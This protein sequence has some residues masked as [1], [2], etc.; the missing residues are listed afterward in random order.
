MN[1][2]DKSAAISAAVCVGMDGS[3]L[4]RQLFSFERE[5]PSGKHFHFQENL[6]KI[7]HK[8]MF[9]RL[10]LLKSGTSKKFNFYVG[11]GIKRSK[12]SSDLVD[13]NFSCAVVEEVEEGNCKDFEE[14]E[15]KVEKIATEGKDLI[16][17]IFRLR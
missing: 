1:Q 11:S 16:L 5:G 7:S 15:I 12:S 3:A 17:E 2:I 14:E 13:R 9:K 6:L 4:L 10:T 8:K